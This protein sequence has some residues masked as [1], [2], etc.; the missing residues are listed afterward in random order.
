MQKTL[1]VLEG[2][3]AVAM[4]WITGALLLT[5][6]GMVMAQSNSSHSQPELVGAW[7]V[8]VTLRDCATNAPLGPAINSLVTFHRGGTLSET[9]AS[10]AFAIGQR[11][12][13]TGTWLRQR[14]QTYSQ[15]MVALILFNSD[16]NAPGTPGF[17]PNKPVSPGFFAGWQT[18]THTVQVTDTDRLASSGTN[19]FYKANG[20]LYR[21]GCSTA[22]GQRFK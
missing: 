9:A 16:P 7:T 8:Q 10:L 5:S 13:G 12:P 18:V 2:A 6:D 14:G 11:S 22:I 17:D 15:R 19:A 20:D 3:R 1:K 4:L 21:T